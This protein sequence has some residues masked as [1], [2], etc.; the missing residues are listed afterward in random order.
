MGKEWL[1]IARQLQSIA[2]AGLTFSDNKYDIDRYKQLKEI[3]LRMINEVTDIRI[4]KLKKIFSAEKGYLTPKVDIRGVVFR[5]EKILMV[6]ENIDGLWS[7]PGGWADVGL[8]PFQVAEKEVLEE[9][10]LVVEPVRLLAVLDKKS[11][12]HPPDLFH[13]YKIFILCHEKGGDLQ[14]G[15]ETCQVAFY[16]IK[17]LPPLSTTRITKEQIEMLFDF[18]NH[19]D[20]PAICD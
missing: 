18:Q 12:A 19:P 2:Q 16:G 17:E 6:K 13:I 1:N 4:E 9:A 14:P 7:I 5:E 8:T 15:I 3:S 20:R 11:H 10:G